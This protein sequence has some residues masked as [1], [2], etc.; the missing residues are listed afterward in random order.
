M[1]TTADLSFSFNRT[2]ATCAGLMALVI[3]YRIGAPVTTSI[4][5]RRQLIDNI[6]YPDANVPDTAADGIDPFLT[7]SHSHLAT[8]SA[9]WPPT[10][11]HRA[12]VYFGHFD[13]D[14]TPQQFRM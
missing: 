13:L 4:S 5:F 14:N 7:C 3:K 9:S 8:I 1:T 11:F 10:Y 12:V 6:L 2:P